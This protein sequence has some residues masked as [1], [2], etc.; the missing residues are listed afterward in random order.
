MS[1]FDDGYVRISKKTHSPC[2]I[3][4][5][6]VDVTLAQNSSCPRSSCQANQVVAMSNDDEAREKVMEM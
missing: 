6:S 2:F 5:G 3:L 4:Q 1:T